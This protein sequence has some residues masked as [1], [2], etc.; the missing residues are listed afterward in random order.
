MGAS[1]DQTL[2]MT[3]NMQT[4]EKTLRPHAGVRFGRG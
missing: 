1:G 3:A 2:Y 4:I